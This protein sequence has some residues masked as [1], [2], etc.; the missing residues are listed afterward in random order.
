MNRYVNGIRKLL[1]FVALASVI[2]GCGARPDT[3]GE[4]IN[5][6]AGGN[7]PPASSEAEATPAP[8]SAMPSSAAFEG[9]ATPT[10]SPTAEVKQAA[11]FA[12]GTDP[13]MKSLTKRSV[14]IG[15]TSELELL[16][17]AVESL[18]A[19]DGSEGDWVPLW[20]G[21]EI[22]SVK[23]EDREAVI[24]VHV[25]DEAR[26]G[27]S[28][29]LMMLDALKDTLFQLQFVESIE[30]L[31]DGEAAE[32]MMGHMEIERPMTRGIVPN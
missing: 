30:L 2:A 10:P 29:E 18:R 28:W 16:E 19:A 17:Q 27:A 9:S 32:S 4:M 14:A 20:K 12:Y 3:G 8:E 21:I 1:A 25:P 22:L 26:S 31:V 5:G 15:Y 6:A 11:I 13:D 24:D 7:T 23:L